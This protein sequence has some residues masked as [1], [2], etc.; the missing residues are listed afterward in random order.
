MLWTIPAGLLA[1]FVLGFLGAGGTIVALPVLLFLARLSPHLS[2][3]T[4]ALGVSFIAAALVTWRIS[5]NEVPLFGGILFAVAG[6][7][8][9]F[10]G[11]H[12]G[13]LYPGR[14]LVFLMG[15]L[16]F[17]VA[18][19]MY[20]LSV[21][22]KSGLHSPTNVSKLPTAGR[23]AGSQIGMMAA[24]AFSIGTAA[25]FFGIGGGFMIVPGLMLVGGMELSLASAASL[26]PIAAFAGVVGI[27]YWAA[28]M[29]RVSWSAAMLI[30]GLAGGACGVWLSQRLSKVVML[31]I[32]A[33]FLVAL[34]IYMLLR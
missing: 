17:V 20:Y 18:G 32:F 31:Q 34:G 5:R 26:I 29:V 15:F 25:G 13:L 19:W 2:L 4:N 14:K 22:H 30:A 24:T 28:D 27:E 1:G 11:A 23:A 3:G 9:I 21:R 10:L 16:L 33:A 7:P 8:G 12:L 6:A